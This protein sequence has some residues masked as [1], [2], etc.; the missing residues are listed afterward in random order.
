MKGVRDA[1]VKDLEFLVLLCQ[2][3][4]VVGFEDSVF[5]GNISSFLHSYQ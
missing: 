1:F 3:E 4:I 5:N 2:G